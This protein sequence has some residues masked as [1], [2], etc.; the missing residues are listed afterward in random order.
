MWFIGVEVEQ[1]TGAPPPKKNPGS[2]PA[3]LIFFCDLPPTLRTK[4]TKEKTFIGSRKCDK[5]KNYINKTV[6][7][8]KSNCC[9]LLVSIYKEVS[10][11]TPKARAKIGSA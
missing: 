3:F 7:Q 2:A 5:M 4:L 8:L 9:R 6:E 11:N 10:K 1:E